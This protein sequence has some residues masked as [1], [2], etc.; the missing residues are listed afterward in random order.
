MQP[1]PVC[2]TSRPPAPHT[3]TAGSHLPG[4]CRIRK[5]GQTRKK[6]TAG[7]L[8]LQ[9]E[10]DS[11]NPTTGR[12]DEVAR[13]LHESEAGQNMPPALCGRD[14]RPQRVRCSRPPSRPRCPSSDTS[15]K[16]GRR[17]PDASRFPVRG[18]VVGLIEWSRPKGA[19]LPQEWSPKE[20]LANWT[21]VE[22]A[23]DLVANKSGATRL[24]FSLLLKFFELEG[25]FPD[26]LEEV[27]PAAVEYVA[28]L[29]KVPATDFTKYT[30]V[31]R[32]A[33]YHR[34]QIRETLGFKPST[35]ADEKAPAE[36]MA[37]EVCPV[38][39]E[40]DRQPEALLVESRARKIEPPGRTQVEKVLVA[41]RGKLEKTFCAR[42]IGRLGEAGTARLLSLVAEDNEAGTG[43]PAALKRDPGAVGLDSPLTPTGCSQTARRSWWPPGGH[44]RSRCTPRTSAARR[45]TYGSPCSPHC[46]R[47]VTRRS[48]TP[49]SSCS[50]WT[51][52]EASAG[53]T[54]GTPPLGRPGTARTTPPTGSKPDGRQ[55]QGQPCTQSDQSSRVSHRPSGRRMRHLLGSCCR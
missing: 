55:P 35:V 19:G 12:R 15:R 48:P 3:D 40:E 51:C 43:L 14:R 28:D 11:A 26:V 4:R 38:K 41:A 1:A 33:E 22:G 45:R 21:L 47:P 52:W 9:A 25:R 18:A 13:V 36:W 54:S 6:D 53:P 10:S 16:A 39:L 2:G 49:W 17:Q 27:P 5:A 8:G 30:L 20:L 7:A 24:G 29:V 31:G 34:K 23:W 37:V 50:C 32:A 44:R 46:A 42:T